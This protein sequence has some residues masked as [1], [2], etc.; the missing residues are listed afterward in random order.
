ML[1]VRV[2]TAVVLLPVALLVLFVFPEDAFA[3]SVGLVVL[4]GAWEWIRLSGVVNRLVTLNLLLILAGTLIWSYFLPLTHV[5][6]LLSIGCIFWIGASALVIIYPKSQ[7]QLGG[8][9]HET[10]VWVASAYACICGS[11]I[12]PQTRSARTVYGGASD[13]NM[14]S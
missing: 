2:L 14:G 1:K 8:R 4:I 11:L 10:W 9:C 3:F 6:V 5:P 13:D 7:K 12:S